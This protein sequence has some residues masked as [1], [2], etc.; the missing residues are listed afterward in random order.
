MLGLGGNWGIGNRDGGKVT[1]DHH[2]LSSPY[3]LKGMFLKLTPSIMTPVVQDS[4]NGAMK[5]MGHLDDMPLIHV[6][7]KKTGKILCHLNHRKKLGTTQL[8]EN[9]F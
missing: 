4:S 2:K 9:A 3:V 6:Y 5:H 1:F 8:S 7:R